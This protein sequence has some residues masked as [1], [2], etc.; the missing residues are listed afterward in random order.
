[1]QLVTMLAL[2]VTYPVLCLG[3]V[4]WMA[5]FED[6]LPDAVRKAVRTPDPPPILAIPVRPSAEPA[7]PMEPL[8]PAVVDLVVPEQRSGAADTL[9]TTRTG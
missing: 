4:L 6:S 7:E 3:F 8:E 9:P 5:R 2:V 1:M